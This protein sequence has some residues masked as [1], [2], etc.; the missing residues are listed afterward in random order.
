M[1]IIQGHRGGE[2][3][4]ITSIVQDSDKLDT[5]AVI[6]IVTGSNHSD[7]TVPISNLRLKHET[8]PTALPTQD[9]FKKNLNV[10][11]YNAGEL[12][13]YNNQKRFGLIVQTSPESLNVLNEQNQ[14][15]QVKIADVSK[16]I[17]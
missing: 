10:E 9:V 17:L 12:I 7:L 2:S 16:K 8:D 14:F 6:S 1:R 15:D 4:I 11:T 13:L 3:G 5:H